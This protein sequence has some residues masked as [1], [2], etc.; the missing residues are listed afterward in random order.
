[1]SF[2]QMT[3]SDLKKNWWVFSQS[4]GYLGW[5]AGCKPVILA[6][7]GK[8]HLVCG[9]NQFLLGLIG[10]SVGQQTITNHLSPQI[11]GIGTRHGGIS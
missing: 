7:R 9:L 5:Q 8:G 2:L 1:M 6:A 4:T 3:L 10:G 11:E